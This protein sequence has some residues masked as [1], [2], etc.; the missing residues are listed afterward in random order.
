[1]PQTLTNCH[2]ACAKNSQNTASINTGKYRKNKLG[3]VIFSPLR[4]M[5][6][7]SCSQIANTWCSNNVPSYIDRLFQKASVGWGLFG[8]KN[9]QKAG[10]QEYLVWQH[11]WSP[12]HTITLACGIFLPSWMSGNG[13][14]LRGFSSVCF[15]FEHIQ[16]KHPKVQLSRRSHLFYFHCAV[17]ARFPCRPCRSGGELKPWTWQCFGSRWG[18]E[19]LSYLSLTS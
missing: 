19:P 18:H 14:S 8:G 6:Y 10:Q 4:Q 16:L 9:P 15:R 12:F 13:C 3:W 1:M 5:N 11:K 2:S 7:L 17:R